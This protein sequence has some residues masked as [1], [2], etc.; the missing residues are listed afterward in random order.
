MR[1]ASVVV[2]LLLCLLPGCRREQSPK[3]STAE[4]AAF[5][6]AYSGSWKGPGIELTI[7]TLGM[8]RYRREGAGSASKSFTAPLSTVDAK[9]FTVGLLGLTTTFR[10]DRPPH[11]EGGARRMTIDGVELTR[12]ASAGPS[13]PRI[14]V[15]TRLDGDLCADPA[16]ELPASVELIRMS[17]L[18]ARGPGVGPSFVVAWIAEDVGEAAPANHTIGETPLEIQGAPSEL[19]GYTI[20]GS[21]ARPRKGW[22]PG[23]YRVE[24]RSGG[25][26]LQTARFTIVAAKPAPGAP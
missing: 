14:A 2:P 7:D 17:A 9:S 20:K 3:A 24:V 16:T 18:V 13:E 1:S 6:K 19:T 22:P 12:A 21:L 5:I 26:P 23:S 15:C 11:E 25:K 8:L 10:I 4:L